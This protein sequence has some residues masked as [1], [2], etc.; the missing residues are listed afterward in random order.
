MT[1]TELEKVLINEERPS[2][3]F[4]D[5]RKS[6]EL[7]RIYPE[8][9]ALIN[10]PQN[11]EYHLEGDVWT[12]TMMVLDEA[13]KR[14]STVNFPF[15]FMLSVLCHD[16]GKAVST[17]VDENGTVHSYEHETAGLPI[18]RK[19]LERLGAD[20]KLIGYVLNMTKLHMDPNIMARAGSKIKKTNKLFDSA[21]EPYDLIELA[22]CDGLGKLPKCDDSEYFLLERLD[23][24]KK[25]MARPYATL[26]DLTDAG[27]EFGDDTDEILSYAHKLRL[28]GVDRESQ[29]RHCISYQRTLQRKNDTD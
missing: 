2:E 23:I 18:V 17:T 3:Y 20:E 11:I 9:H 28:A 21:E 25:T 22:V 26:K 7:E 5:I 6:G 4:E 8:I 29:I 24:Y 12:H 1:I 10:V 27:M 15:G 13:T 16:F 14:R 19:F